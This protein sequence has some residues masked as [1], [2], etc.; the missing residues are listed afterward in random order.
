MTLTD[1]IWKITQ[2]MAPNIDG[3]MGH[4]IKNRKHRRPGTQCVIQYPTNKSRAQYLQESAIIDKCIWASV[5]QLVA[6]ISER[7]RKC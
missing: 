2:H 6:K 7:H 4:T 1:T 3:T 5:V